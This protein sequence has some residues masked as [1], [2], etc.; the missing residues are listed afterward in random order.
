MPR[1][2][3]W[4]ARVVK[5]L[6]VLTPALLVWGCTGFAASPAPIA[7][8]YSVQDRM[9]LDRDAQGLAVSQTVARQVLRLM[10]RAVRDQ[11]EPD[12]CVLSYRVWYRTADS[13]R[14]VDVYALTLAE[15][16]SSDSVTIYSHTGRIC[17]DGVPSIHGHVLRTW[18]LPHPS[19]A[20]SATLVRSGAPFD[21]LAFR[22]NSDSS[23][24]VRV[25]WNGEAR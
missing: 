18:I 16:D 13:A 4:V 17:P 10:E 1:G 2:I 21:L 3:R 7:Q 23:F 20:D 8:P 25:F 15:D 5:I 22:L 9:M 12:A 24:G 19:Q 6:K 11:R 14:M